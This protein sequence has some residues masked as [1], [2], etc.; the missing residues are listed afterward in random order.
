M[1]ASHQKCNAVIGYYTVS[2]L[3][4][5]IILLMET[6]SRTSHQGTCTNTTARQLFSILINN[7]YWGGIRRTSRVAFPVLLTLF[8]HVCILNCLVNQDFSISLD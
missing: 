1:V 3:L 2:N 7:L 6:G 8:F 4:A 5:V